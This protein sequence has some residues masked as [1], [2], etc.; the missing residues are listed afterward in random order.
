MPRSR[1]LPAWYPAAWILVILL[2]IVFSLV[3]ALGGDGVEVSGADVSF[4][5]KFDYILFKIDDT[6]AFEVSGDR[7]SVMHYREGPFPFS[8][9]CGRY[10]R[11]G[12]ALA[13]EP[14]RDGDWIYA[15]SPGGTWTDW[16]A[17]R[18]LTTGETLHLSAAE[19]ERLEDVPYN[20]RGDNALYHDRGWVVDQAHRVTP[21]QVAREFEAMSTLNESSLAIQ[22]A[23]LMASGLLIMI[24]LVAFVTGRPRETPVPL[25]DEP[26]GA[27]D[28]AGPTP[29]PLSDAPET[30]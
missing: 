19:A 10:E 14:L 7:V 25:N 8:L 28:A 26:N 20:E 29:S 23:F 13:G 27:A 24:G 2:W 17:A 30:R 21:E 4:D 6:T 9:L 12:R 16:P 11:D 5:R 15:D 1:R 18:N 3:Y 22:M